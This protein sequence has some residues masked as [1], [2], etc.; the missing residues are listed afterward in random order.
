MR[1]Q[2]RTYSDRCDLLHGPTYALPVLVSKPAVV[3]IHDVIALTHPFFCTPGSARV[4][5]RVIPRS[6]A[7]ARRII[8]PTAATKE[9]LLRSV[10]E[11]DP[12]PH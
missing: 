7:A 4:Q 11:A 8:V 10:K 12:E 5:K 2:S 6:V 3:T 9:E 1:L